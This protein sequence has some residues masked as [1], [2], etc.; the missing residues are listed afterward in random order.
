MIF[1]GFIDWILGDLDRGRLDQHSHH[2]LLRQARRRRG[3][4]ARLRARQG[5]FLSLCLLFIFIVFFL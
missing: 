3:P 2:R 1:N 5:T 4:Q